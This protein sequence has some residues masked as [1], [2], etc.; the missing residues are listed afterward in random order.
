MKRND[1]EA[2][3]QIAL[4]QWASY[5]RL[6]TFNPRFPKEMISDYLVHIPNE[7]KRSLIGNVKQKKM[8]LKKGFPDL[9]LLIPIYPYCGLFIEMKAKGKKANKEQLAWKEKL[10]C[11]FGDGQLSY[12]AV[13]CDGWELAS[14]NINAYLRGD[15]T[16]FEEII[17]FANGAE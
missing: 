14:A 15:L 3:E 8:G 2:Q 7:G 16:S 10:N 6:D 5:Q 17:G 9:M 1:P 4:M 12:V 11:H 13:V